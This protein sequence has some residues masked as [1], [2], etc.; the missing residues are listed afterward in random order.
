MFFPNAFVLAADKSKNQIKLSMLSIGHAYRSFTEHLSDSCHFLHLL[1][2]P[3][4]KLYI[5]RYFYIYTKHTNGIYFFL[6]AV[7]ILQGRPLPILACIS[8]NCFLNL[9]FCI[10]LFSTTSEIICNI[11]SFKLILMFI[12]LFNKCS[13]IS[14]IKIPYSHSRVIYQN[15]GH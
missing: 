2:Y 5:S 9:L 3:W 12:Q 15:M 13:S 6:Q 1:W 11:S 7:S 14:S 8:S 4:S 10:Y